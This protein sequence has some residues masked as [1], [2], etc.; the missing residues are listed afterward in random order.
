[1]AKAKR[2][3]DAHRREGAVGFC[4]PPK[5]HRFKPGHPGNPWGCKGKPKADKEFLDE[6]QR[7]LIDGKWRW[8]TRDQLIDIALYKAVVKDGNVSAAKLL[9][10][11]KEARLAKLSVDQGEEEL[12]PDEEAALL[13]A[14]QR[15]LGRTDAQGGGEKDD[16]DP[17]DGP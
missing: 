15:R 7:V 9:D 16:P 1:M 5:E 17:E 8:L 2:R 4:R 11:R 6:R 14:A 12:S 10:A 13:R 3:G